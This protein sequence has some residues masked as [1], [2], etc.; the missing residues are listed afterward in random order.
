MVNLTT[1]GRLIDNETWRGEILISGDIEIPRGIT[2]T[3]QPGTII[4]FTAGQDDRSTGGWEDL[5]IPERVYFPDDPPAVPAK[6][7]VISVKG[8][9]DA[10]GTAE[11][12]ILFT[13]DSPEPKL[14]DWQSISLEEG[15]TVKL[16]NAVVE[17]NY[18][19]LQVNANR[20]QLTLVNS[21]FRHI[22]TC[23][24]CTGNHPIFTTVEISGNTFQDCQHEGVDTHAE[25][26]LIVKNNLFLDNV[27]GVVAND[28]STILVEG[29]TFRHNRTGISINNN[30]NGPIVRGNVFE[31]QT[32]FAIWLWGDST[33][34]IMGNNFIGN[35]GTIGLGNSSLEVNAVDNWWD[36]T[37]ESVIRYYI[38]D[39]LDQSGLGLVEYLPFATSPFALDAP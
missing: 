1:T 7:I 22:A 3:V 2:L 29:N 10:R 16:D 37:D 12:P 13:S 33:A 30:A 26:Q 25:Q 19:G 24:V 11:Q 14:N 15:G 39:G 9:L 38:Q 8:T 18:W 21:I 20:P 32:F 31:H 6:M 28:G 35:A 36:T 23:G 5:A 34:V 17:Y 4:R 27:V